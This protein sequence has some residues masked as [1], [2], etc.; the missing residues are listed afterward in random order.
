[1]K[2]ILDLQKYRFHVS[3]KE[4]KRR[5]IEESYRTNFRKPEMTDTQKKLHALIESEKK[6]ILLSELSATEPVQ[7]NPNAHQLLDFYTF[8]QEIYQPFKTQE[9]QFQ[10]TKPQLSEERKAF[11]QDLKR[12]NLES[13]I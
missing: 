9:S 6:R 3:N 12:K 5:R 11:F 1:M 8:M 10:Y 2:N 4:R 7:I 13:K